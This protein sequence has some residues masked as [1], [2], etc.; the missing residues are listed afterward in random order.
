MRGGELYDKIVDEGE[1]TDEEAKPIVLQI[2]SA[3]EYLH[4]NG[5]AHRDLKVPRRV[6]RLC[7]CF[8]LFVASLAVSHK[9]MQPENLLCVDLSDGKRP[10]KERIKVADFGLSKMFVEEDLTSQCGS[11]TYVGT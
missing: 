6:F 4:K 1:F 5:I 10:R 7:V 3:I 8:L 2:V 11:P 9:K